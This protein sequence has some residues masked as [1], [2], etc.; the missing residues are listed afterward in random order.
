MAGWL[1]Q[2][3]LRASLFRGSTLSPERKGIWRTQ[4]GSGSAGTPGR[5]RPAA[6]STLPPAALGSARRDGNMKTAWGPA[7]QRA[8]QPVQSPGCG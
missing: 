3:L 6:A 5:H 2:S 1:R 4:A 8:V 7:P